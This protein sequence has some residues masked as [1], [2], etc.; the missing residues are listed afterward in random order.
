MAGFG[1]QKGKKKK[2][3]RQKTQI[4]GD[5]LLK[6][7]I[8]H[9]IQGD[10]KNAE[11]DYRAAIDSGLLNVSLFSN[12]GIIC[13]ETQ[14]TEEA[15]SLYKKAIQINPNDPNA[16]TNLG[17]LHQ[18]LGNLDEALTSTLKS[19][20]LKPDNP[21]AY[22]NLGNIY[23]DLGNLDQALTSTIKSL[24]LK[25]N[26]PD[27]HMNLGGIYKDLGN[28]DQAL[29]STLKSLE[30]KPDNPTAHMNLGSIYK[31]LGNLDQALASTLKSL[32]LKPDNPDAHMNLGGI[33][34]D[35]GNL[36]QA[37]ASTLKS[38]E[39]KPDNPGAT[40]NLKAFIDQLN[41][42]PSNAKEVTQAYELLLNQTDISHKDLS[43]IFL[44]AFL[45]IIQKAS[46][47]DPIISDGNQALKALAAD[48]RFL[49]S[50]TLMIPPS[51]EAEAFFTRLRK[52]LLK[53]TIQMGT[54]P[55]H[56]KYLTESLAA[57]CFLNEYVY[58]SSPEEDDSIAQL[59]EAAAHKQEDTNRY[60]VI[61]ACY[62]AI[63]TTGISPEFI[64][65]YPIPDDSSKE[66]ITAQFK[67]PLQEQEIKTSFQDKR[68]VSDTIS[69]KVQEMY[70]ENPYPRF[71]FADYTDSKLAKPIFKAI[72]Q[73][74][75]KTDL[76][77]IEELKSP[78]ATP[79]VL[80]AGCGTGN[81][82]IMASR[83]KKAQITAIDLSS[84]SLAYAIRKTKEY[85]MNNITFKQMDLLNVA[86]LGATFDIIECGGVLH[87]MEQPADGLS[88]LVQQLKPGCYIKLGLYSEIARKVIVKARKTIQMLGINSSPESIREF[89]K[90]VRNGEIHDLLDL[91]K[92][93][94]DF[95]S[96]SE[97]RDLCFHVQEHRFTT[98]SL[99]KLL[100]S[101]GLTFCGFMVPEKIKKLYQE[102]YPEDI[103]M[104]S[105]PN[106]GEF[107]EKILQPS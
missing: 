96:L 3:P 30:L 51:S 25:P 8:K 73:E 78:T 62:K 86:N 17:G 57:Q 16:Y 81:Q 88:A 43:K 47:S 58:A 87:H 23:K 45:P 95:Y 9:H 89:R 92:F 27:A 101:H 33:Y 21:S 24:E 103:D 75:S 41:I 91:P 66:L 1:E 50:L 105:L 22:M 102:Q 37:L 90:K 93:I 34:K 18:N 32:E 40:S 84:S 52:E 63:H 99:K 107:E 46:A 71:K 26:N 61:I 94:N 39:L 13:Q 20:E 56:L 15:I 36:D 76:S 82:V 72:E 85:G 79:K 104:T 11:K 14:R 29:A 77:F 65:N 19:L 98:D 60:L 10:L 80:I 31:D 6:N 2:R 67:E 64:N 38:L 49:K 74:T 83:Y 12:L 53:L 48:W 69:Q 55:E 28:L 4:S 35:L 97:C 54:V 5:I 42:S 7:A 68:N 44:Q 106:W 59:I 70:E 100:D